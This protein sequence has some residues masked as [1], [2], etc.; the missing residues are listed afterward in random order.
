[1]ATLGLIGSG[2]IG[3]TLAHLAVDPGLGV[4]ISNSRAPQT[5]SDLVDELGPQAR[6]ATPAQ[7]AAAGDWGRHDDP[8][9]CRGPWTRPTA[10]PCRSQATTRA[11]RS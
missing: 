1:M 7:A 4:V 6:A 3:G 8:G 11:Q 5:L 10:P 9:P 2:N